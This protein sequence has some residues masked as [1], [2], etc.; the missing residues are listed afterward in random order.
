MFYS[1]GVGGRRSDKGGSVMVIAIGRAS[2]LSPKGNATPFP[3]AQLAAAIDRAW[4]PEPP[5]FVSKQI[6][7]QGVSAVRAGGKRTRAGA[8]D[9]SL[10]TH[11]HKVKVSSRPRFGTVTMCM[12]TIPLCC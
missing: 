11:S 7:S 1:V 8:T 9:N 12:A 5:Q 3:G 10:K 6:Y 4:K 2:I